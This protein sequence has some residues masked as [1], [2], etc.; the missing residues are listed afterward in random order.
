MDRV[1]L[2]KLEELRKEQGHTERTEQRPALY[3]PEP[4]VILSGSLPLE[5]PQQK[6]GVEIIDFTI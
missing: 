6:R 2:D 5:E 4:M 1:P 3:A